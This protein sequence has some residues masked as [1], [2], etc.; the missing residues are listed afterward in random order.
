MTSLAGNQV[1]YSRA[2]TKRSR[3]P[4]PS[5]I[6]TARAHPAAETT[7]DAPT[8]ITSGISGL[9][10]AKKTLTQDFYNIIVVIMIPPLISLEGAPWMVLPPGVHPA[11][12]AEVTET[13]GTNTRRREILGGFIDAASKLKI[14]GCTK[15]YLDGSFVTGKPRPGDFDACW[16]PAGVDPQKLDPVFLNFSNG[17]A[18]QKAMFKGEFFPSSL[19]CADVGRTF[20]EFFQIDRFTGKK[21]GIVSIL[22]STDLALS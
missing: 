7:I 9:T 20:A 4:V 21:K 13:F 15:I 18:Q 14:A 12:I 16:E 11:T 17:R 2:G 5:Q 19:V 8:P 6:I 3:S 22:L 10:A 1:F